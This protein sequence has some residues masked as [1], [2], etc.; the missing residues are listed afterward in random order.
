L[1]TFRKTDP[2]AFAKIVIHL[3]GENFSCLD[4]GCIWAEDI[5]ILTSITGPTTEASFRLF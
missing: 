5:T 1:G 4:D 2:T 3:M